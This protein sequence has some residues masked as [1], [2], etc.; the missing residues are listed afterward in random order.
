MTDALAA[1]SKAGVSIWLDDLSRERLVSGSLADLAARDHVVGRDHQPDDL[2]QGDH[3]QRRLRAAASGPGRARRRGR[4]GAAGADHVRRALGL[5]RAA[6]GLRRDRRGGRAGLDRG[7]PAAR[8]RHRG[9]DRRG[10]GPVVAGG[11]A[12]PVHQDPGRPAGPAGDRRVPGRGDQHQCHADLLPAAATTQ[13]I[14]RLPRRHGTR[15]AGRPRPVRRSGRWPRSSSP[16]ST[17]R[18]TPGW[19]RS[20]PARRPRCAA[21][22]RSPTRGW[23]TSTTSRCSPR[24]G[25]RRCARPEPGR[26]GRCGP[27]HRSRTPPTPTP[28]T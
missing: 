15:P 5:R 28:A 24:R 26:S 17:P 13:V 12:Q 8:P 4:R 25:G 14:G 23:P 11:P 16:G 19:T 3:R 6:A 1:L 9:D 20:A 10:A 27:R 7:R 21:G 2:R 18:S 22:P